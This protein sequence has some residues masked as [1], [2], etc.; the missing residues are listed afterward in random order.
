MAIG[1]TVNVQYHLLYFQYSDK[2][3]PGFKKSPT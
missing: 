3:R 2:K 1:H